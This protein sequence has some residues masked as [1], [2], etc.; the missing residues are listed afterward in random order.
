MDISEAVW[1]QHAGAREVPTSPRHT[2]ILKP[3]GCLII[4]FFSFSI[5]QLLRPFVNL[6]FATN[7]AEEFS[8]E[9]QWLHSSHTS[10]SAKSTCVLEK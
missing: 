10:I 9:A 6:L 8:T 7:R 1:A 2:N 5:T 3:S 4:L